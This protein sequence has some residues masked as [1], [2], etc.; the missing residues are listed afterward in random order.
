MRVC[1]CEEL[2]QQRIEDRRTAGV[3]K[4]LSVR[5]AK[6][7]GQEQDGGR[8]YLEEVGG[9]VRPAALVHVHLAAA[10]ADDAEDAGVGYGGLDGQRLVVQLLEPLCV[11][12]LR[13]HLDLQRIDLQ[14]LRPLLQII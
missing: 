12:L 11:L 2:Q 9:G 1:F 8:P 14:Q 13:V 10:L 4:T 7:K 5:A 3:L 6:E